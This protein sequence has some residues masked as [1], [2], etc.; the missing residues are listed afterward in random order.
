MAIIYKKVV[1]QSYRILPSH[2]NYYAENQ[3]LTFAINLRILPLP[4]IGA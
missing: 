1:S 3:I 2:F 4:I